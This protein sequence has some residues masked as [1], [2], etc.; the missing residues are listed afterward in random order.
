MLVGTRVVTVIKVDKPISQVTT[1]QIDPTPGTC[2]RVSPLKIFFLSLLYCECVP[3]AK[4]IQIAKCTHLDLQKNCWL[5]IPVF[6]IQA[7]RR[8]RSSHVNTC[9][10]KYISYL[11]TRLSGIDNAYTLEALRTGQLALY[12]C[13]P[14]ADLVLKYFPK[15][16]VLKIP[17]SVVPRSASPHYPFMYNPLRL[18]TNWKLLTP[19]QRE[20]A[21]KKE[22]SN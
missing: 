13:C 20:Y 7:W 18:G 22:I 2:L 1:S 17:Q 15:Q 16:P 21:Y 4:C 12:T 11:T 14:L 6:P 9:V 10:C 19:A 8:T 3:V 5:I